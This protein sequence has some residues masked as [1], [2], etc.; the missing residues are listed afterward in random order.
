M[1]QSS[2]GKNNGKKKAWDA[3]FEIMPPFFFAD[4]WKG[5]LYPMKPCLSVEHTISVGL[6]IL[7]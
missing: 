2:Q 4:R 6:R 1:L 7:D 5:Q 3:M